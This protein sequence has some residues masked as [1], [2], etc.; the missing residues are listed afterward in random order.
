M[1]LDNK[2]RC[3]QYR[4]F[5]PS[6]GKERIYNMVADRVVY[7]RQRTWNYPYFYCEDCNKEII[8]DTTIKSILKSYLENTAPTYWYAKEAQDLIPEGLTC[9]RW[10]F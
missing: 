9:P 6:W 2:L 3:N 10:Q 8:N 5:I 1:V 4:R 7:F